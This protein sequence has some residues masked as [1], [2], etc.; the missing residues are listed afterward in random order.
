[1]TL[2]I[3]LS[4]LSLL[5]EI[6][7][8]QQP[9][10]NNLQKTIHVDYD[11]LFFNK[12][13][14]SYLYR[15]YYSGFYTSTGRP[16]SAYAATFATE[17]FSFYPPTKDGC[18]KL[19]K[20]SD[21]SSKIFEC[22]Y[23]TNGA[24]FTTDYTKSLC[25]GNLI[26][27]GYVW[28]LPTD[29]SGTGRVNYGVTSSNSVISGFINST[30]IENSK[31]TQL[32]T[33]WG[34]LVRNG[35][36]FV[37]SSQDLSF[38]PDGFTYEKAPRTSVGIFKNGSMILFE[39]DGE[40]DIDAGPDLFELAELLVSIGVDSAINIDG[41]GSSVSVYEGSVIDKPTCADTPTVCER[42]VASITC[43]RY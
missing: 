36:S 31:F 43:V 10:P 38:Q 5:L 29:G 27:D 34:W 4:F 14:N 39:V 16:Y 17:Y 22:K 21:S 9:N 11:T 33:G 42:A 23:A 26:S 37:N 25:V 24:F 35:V 2:C 41:G 20:P 13:E 1:M 19:V 40:E 18:T 28:Q 12:T 3:F 7:A 15:N 32:I 8:L 6:N 30:V